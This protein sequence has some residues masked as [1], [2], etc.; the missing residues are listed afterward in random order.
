MSVW[1]NCEVVGTSSKILFDGTC[2]VQWTRQH[3]ICFETCFKQQR[4]QLSLP[5]KRIIK[6]ASTIIRDSR[7]VP[8]HWQIG[9]SGRYSGPFSIATSLHSPSRSVRRLGQLGKFNSLVELIEVGE[10]QGAT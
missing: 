3:N 7:T 4:S 8:V 10:G 1:N 5:D 2:R 9:I 6:R